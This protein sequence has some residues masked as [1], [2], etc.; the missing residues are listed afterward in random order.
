M[1]RGDLK[2]AIL[3]YLQAQQRTAP[4]ANDIG[5]ALELRGAQKKRLQKVLNDIP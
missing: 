5:R 2:Q 1:K 3:A 4:S